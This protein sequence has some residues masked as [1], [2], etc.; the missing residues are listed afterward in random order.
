MKRKIFLK[1]F[2]KALGVEE[3]L[4]TNSQ[5]DKIYGTVIYDISAPIER[6]DFVWHMTEN[7]VPSE[8]AKKLLDFLSKN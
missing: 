2:F 1:S 7:D 6:Q 5:T 8:D 4:W 3:I